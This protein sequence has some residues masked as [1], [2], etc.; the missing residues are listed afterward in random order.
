M[1]IAAVILVPLVISQGIQTFKELFKDTKNLLEKKK[2][3]YFEDVHRIS[4]SDAGLLEIKD[5][6]EFSIPQ[7]KVRIQTGYKIA[8]KYSQVLY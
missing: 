8:S 4:N 5:I 1:L 3:I 7:I 6:V 2:F